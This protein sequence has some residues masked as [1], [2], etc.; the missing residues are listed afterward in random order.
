MKENGRK[1]GQ[2]VSA[3]ERFRPTA[4]I[5]F[6][7][8][9]FSWLVLFLEPPPSAVLGNVDHAWSTVLQ[10]AAV[11]GMKVGSDLAF[12]YGP[13]GWMW[14][15]EVIRIPDFPWVMLFFSAFCR[16]ALFALV[17]WALPTPQRRLLAAVFFFASGFIDYGIDAAIL[18][19]LLVLIHAVVGARVGMRRMEHWGSLGLTGAHWG[20]VLGD[21][22]L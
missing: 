6:F 2:I 3:S 8:L 10:Y 20:L 9:G 7:L 21:C 16:I 17:I 22:T 18:F 4:Y 19:G 12:T 14:T 1:K 11:A 5:A 15:L 13:L